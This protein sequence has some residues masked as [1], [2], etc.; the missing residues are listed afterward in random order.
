MVNVRAKTNRE[1]LHVNAQ[2]HSENEHIIEVSINC[3]YKFYI[4]GEIDHYDITSIRD[5]TLG[6][7]SNLLAER[8]YQQ[9]NNL[10]MEE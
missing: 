2:S 6:R 10:K 9:M 1:T 8:F 5:K 7:I 3:D 4:F